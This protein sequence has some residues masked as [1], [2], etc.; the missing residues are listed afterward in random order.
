MK[1]RMPPRWYVEFRKDK[2]EYAVVKSGFTDSRH[3]NRMEALERIAVLESIEED[4]LK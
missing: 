3:W 2:R 1:T 4:D